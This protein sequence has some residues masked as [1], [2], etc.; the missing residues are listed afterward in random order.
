MSVSGHHKLE[1]LDALTSQVST[2]A[3]YLLPALGH[4]LVCSVMGW[5]A[6]V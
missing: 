2:T 5:P 6:V 3:A 1:A 4:Q